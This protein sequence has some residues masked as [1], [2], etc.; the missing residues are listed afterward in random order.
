AC[1]TRRPFSPHGE[2]ALQEASILFS[3]I[4]NFTTAAER[5]SVTKVAQ[6]LAEYFQR[7][8][9]V[10]ERHGGHHIKVLG[11]GRMV[12]FDDAT[13]D[14]PLKHAV[15]ALF[16]ALK[17][18][19]AAR[20]FRH[21]LDTWFARR[22][23]PPFAIGA[24]VHCGGVMFGRL[25]SHRAAEETALG[26]AVNTT[27]RIETVS[28]DLGW[29]AVANSEPLARAGKGFAVGRTAHA[30]ICGRSNR[31]T[32][33]EITGLSDAHFA[34]KGVAAPWAWIERIQEA[35]HENT[36]LAAQPG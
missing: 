10:A 23:L 8:C 21:W 33:A 35:I 17:L 20:E 11:D 4:R 18:A 19:E 30:H 9:A 7:A 32:V 14:L 34:F 28:K 1:V 2:V 16:V 29:T 36:A 12:V 3:D 15:R 31:V 5:L 26:D 25:G 22:D 27:A 13:P 24:G 6:I